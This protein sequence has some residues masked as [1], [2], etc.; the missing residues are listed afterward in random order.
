M[1]ASVDLLTVQLLLCA[2]KLHP[3]LIPLL[4]LLNPLLL[5]KLKAIVQILDLLHVN[6]VPVQETVA[7]ELLLS[8][9]K[10]LIPALC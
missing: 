8:P 1:H 10:D 5:F 9:N 2:V 6:F 3:T 4:T 7:G